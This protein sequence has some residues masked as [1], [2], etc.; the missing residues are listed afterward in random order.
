MHILGVIS[1]SIIKKIKDLFLRTTTGT[2]GSST[3]G[4][5]WTNVVGEWQATISYAESNTAVSNSS[6][7][8]AT[9][10][11][12]QNVKA[13]AI[14]S[15]GTGVAFWV[16]DAN[17]WWA[18]TSYS[19]LYAYSCNCSTCYSS[20][21]CSNCKTCQ[22]CGYVNGSCAVY[23]CTAAGYSNTIRSGSS[24]YNRTTGIY[25][26]E[27]ACTSYNRV[28]QCG[29]T[30]SCAGYY[31]CNPYSCN[32]N[33][34]TEQKY[35]LRLLKSVGGV[36]SEATGKVS[37]SSSP[38]KISVTTTGDIINTTAWSSDEMTSTTF[39]AELVYVPTS[40]VKG[41][42]VGII[43]AVSD[44]GQNKYIYGFEAEA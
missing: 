23:S 31:S 24:C 32:C 28:Y 21:Y 4:S 13:N 37:L 9:V 5:T 10:P 33:T 19:D 25:Q 17:S 34:C 1:S 30:Y 20:C 42:N 40:P 26:G 35:Y 39:M 15:I 6:V 44:Y 22:D 29:P 27:A 14:V 36:I 18:S 16:T 3:S 11:L 8:I 7:A 2:L 41:A 43:K 38:Y 12:S